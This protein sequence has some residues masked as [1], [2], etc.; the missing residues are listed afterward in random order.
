VKVKVTGHPTLGVIQGESDVEAIR[1]WRWQ[2][3]CGRCDE[4]RVF[5]P[6]VLHHMVLRQAE[7]HTYACPA[8]RAA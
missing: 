8:R 2:Y 3:Q 6:G 1:L 4:T 7:L 5:S